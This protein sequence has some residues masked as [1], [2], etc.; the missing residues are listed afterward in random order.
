[1]L[2]LGAMQA[3]APAACA[4]NALQTQ[5]RTRINNTKGM[6]GMAYANSKFLSVRKKNQ[7]MS[8]IL[9]M[10]RGPKSANRRS[11]NPDS[12]AA[13]MRTHE[14]KGVPWE[15]D[16]FM[17][18][19]RPEKDISWGQ[20]Y[21]SRKSKN[22]DEF[23][24]DIGN[25]YEDGRNYSIGLGARI[26]DLTPYLLHKVDDRISMAEIRSGVARVA[27]HAPTIRDFL[28]LSEQWG[29]I[30]EMEAVTSRVVVHHLRLLT[31]CLD[32]QATA[33]ETRQKFT[34]EYGI[35]HTGAGVRFYAPPGQPKLTR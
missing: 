25:P 22:P 27:E 7:Q 3:V 1:M 33:R 32:G 10:L 13:W 26:A 20:K 5:R 28:R 4:R 34:T 19:M 24:P 11:Q 9:E 35:L 29:W 21:F 30:E 16:V 31:Q 2:A 18:R 17:H 8:H 12:V 14:M 15:W 23:F 6:S